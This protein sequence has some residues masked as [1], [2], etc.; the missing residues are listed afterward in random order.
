MALTISMMQYRAQ[1]LDVRTAQAAKLLGKIRE[2]VAEKSFQYS[3]IQRQAPKK[4]VKTRSRTV[5]GKLNH[6]LAL[7]SKIYGRNRARLVRLGAPAG[8]LDCYRVL[9][10]ADV[11]ASTALLDPNQMG[12]RSLRLSWIWQIDNMDPSDSPEALQECKYLH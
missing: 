10:A 7:L 1:E 2:A 3:H 12:S 8:V 11:K 9:V 5:I 6:Q 4:S